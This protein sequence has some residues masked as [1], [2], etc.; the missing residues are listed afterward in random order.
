PFAGHPY[1]LCKA[2][3]ILRAVIATFVIGLREGVEA[4]LIVGIVAAFLKQEGRADALRLMWLVAAVAV[5]MVTFMI[6]WMRRHARGLAAELR[7]DAATALAR[8][9]AWA[10][11]GMAFF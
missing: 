6:F 2:T 11:V 8:G 9:S 5:V 3:F 7:A 10:L 4:S 1:S